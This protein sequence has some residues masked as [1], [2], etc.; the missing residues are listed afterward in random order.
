[1]QY[2]QIDLFDGYATFNV[3]GEKKSGEENTQTGLQT[4]GSGVA[5][6]V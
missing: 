5:L 6:N 4:E 1:M 3:S 2:T